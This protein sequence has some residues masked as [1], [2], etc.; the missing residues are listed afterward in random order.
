[1]AR[2]DPA[3]SLPYEVSRD[4]VPPG[5]RDSV[6]VDAVMRFIRKRRLL[7]LAW[8]AAG[9]CAGLV[10]AT[11]TPAYYT[12]SANILLKDQTT[13]SPDAPIG[14]TDAAHSTFVETQVQVF[15][16]DEVVG[17]IVDGQ[18]LASDAEFGGT[19]GNLRAVVVKYVR[20]LVGS[21]SAPARE[22]RYATI[23][24]VRRALSVR[25]IGV[26]DVVEIQFTSRDAV[27]SAMIANA[28]I[29]SYIDSRVAL[30]RS[31]SQQ[32]ALQLRA[33]LAELRDKAFPADPPP[34]EAVTPA[35]QSALEARAHFREQEERT[36]AYRALY[37]RVLRQALGDVSGDLSAANVR[38][39]TPAEPPL[40]ASSRVMILV[41]FTV[42]GGVIGIGHALYGE[43]N[44]R[45]LRTIE[46]VRRSTGFD[47]IVGIPKVKAGGWKVDEALPAYLQPAY[48]K[49]SSHTYGSLSKV[50]VKLQDGTNRRSGWI[51]GIASPTQDTGA[52]SIAVHLARI[53]AES[54]QRTLLLDANWQKS[55][56]G[57][58]LLNSSQSRKLA[59]GLATVHLPAE[60]LD[61]LVLRPTTPISELNA[62]LSIVSTLELLRADYDCIIVD[63]IA[64][65]QTADLEAGVSLLDQVVAVAA[66]RLTTSDSLHGLLRKFPGD[67][68][69]TVIL[70]K[71]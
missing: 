64:S 13:R 28:V 50:A 20:L 19:G 71:I 62:S 59:R 11:I 37:S 6:D 48:R 47:D 49:V 27:R 53:I 56:T 61:I 29:Q 42:L 14:E 54:G 26:S 39:I 65:E 60:T 67:R 36:E 45:S 15:G 63:F 58:T 32:T 12:A 2:N 68:I 10:Y 22:P 21:G 24:R 4:P 70:N 17:R 1:M 8:L 3:L 43:V 66:A 57:Q 69:A 51:I 35:P 33:T 30:Q 34:E 16:S 23:V 25:R 40:L 5:D 55:S 46:D 18:Q 31:A 38:V 44:D 7:C 52:S 9:L 41:A